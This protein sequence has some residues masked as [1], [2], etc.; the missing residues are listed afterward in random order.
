MLIKLNFQKIFEVSEAIPF[1]S[2]VTAITAMMIKSLCLHNQRTPFERHLASR[3]WTYLILS[4]I[5]LINV[6]A[7]LFKQTL[8]EK[9][10]PLNPNIPANKP[11]PVQK[12]DSGLLA[13]TVGLDARA[14]P[15]NTPIGT[16]FESKDILV[17]YSCE[18]VFE[19]YPDEDPSIVFFVIYENKHKKHLVVQ[20][21]P[22]GCSA[23]VA[24][25]L[26]ADLDKTI[27][28]K[29]FTSRGA[30]GWDRIK[31]DLEGLGLV[32]KASDV[33]CCEDISGDLSIKT[34]DAIISQNGP[35]CV[36]IQPPASNIAHWIV[37]DE[38]KLDLNV[39]TIRDP[40]HGMM[41]DINLDVFVIQWQNAWKQALQKNLTCRII[42]ACTPI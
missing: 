10:A 39:V 16:C 9:K 18:N 17:N 12:I 6:I 33:K 23:G 14:Q 37:V 32:V 41:M 21:S 30:E 22:L 19:P 40:W 20:G 35:A 3:T 7:Y 5:P 34:L 29:D 27:P 25:M 11:V 15:A 4:A 8:L 24:A 42:Q 38:I 31:A 26:A 2:T 36:R 28:Y 13:A 1:A